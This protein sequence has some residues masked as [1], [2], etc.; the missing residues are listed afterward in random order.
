MPQTFSIKTDAFSAADLLLESFSCTE[1]LS[2][3]TE[4]TASLLSPRSDLDADLILGKPVTFTVEQR[5]DGARHF[6]GIVSRFSAVGQTGRFHRYQAVVRPWLWFLTRTTDCRIFQHQTV[7]DIVKTVFADHRIAVHDFKLFREYREREYC[8]QYRE[9]DFNFVS[10]LL[11]HEGIY[12]RF[13][14]VDGKHTLLLLDSG[15]A[16]DPQPDGAAELPFLGGTGQEPPDLDFVGRWTMSRSVQPGKFAIDDYDFE[17]P[18]SKLLTSGEQ[19]REHDLGDAEIYDYPGLFTKPADGVQLI[20]TRRDEV[21]SCFEVFSGST[22]ALALRVGFTFKLQRHPRD[23]QN[24]EYLVT[25]VNLQA[26]N[27]SLDAGLGAGAGFHCE[28]T[29]I[30]ASQQ[31]RPPRHSRRPYVQGAQTAVVVGAAGE[32]IHTDR[33]GRVR[34]QFRWDRLGKKDENSSCMVRVAQAWA[35]KNFGAIFIP[36]VGQEVIVDFLEGDPD[37]PI[38]VGSVHNAE[39]MPPWK[40]PDN[41]TQSGVLTRSSKGG[42]Y[43]NANEIRF[44]DKQGSELLSLHAERNMSTSV[45]VDDSTSVG[46]DQSIGI[47]RDQSLSVT[48]NRNVY[49]K[50]NESHIVD[51]A[52]KLKVGTNQ[53]NHVV[54]NQSTQVDGVH[55][56][57]VKGNLQT[58]TQANRVENTKGNESRTIKGS[59]SHFVTGNQIFDI[60]GNLSY[61][62]A[63]MVFE[64]G[65]IEHK[66]TGAN[67]VVH[68]SPNGPYSIM[69]NKIT[70]LSNTDVS[71]LAAGK[72]NQTSMENNVT[73]MGSNNSGYIGTASEVNMGLSR[74][75]FLGLAMDTFIGA[76]ISNTMALQFEAVLA[77]KMS[78]AVGPHLEMNTM[79][80]YCPGGG[81]GAG[82]ATALGEGASLLAGLGALEGIMV[83]FYSTV[84]GLD[85]ISN[86]YKDAKAELNEQAAAAEEAGHPG[87]ATR[88]RRLASGGD[89]GGAA[90]TSTLDAGGGPTAVSGGGGAFDGG[91]AQGNTGAPAGAIQ[92]GGDQGGSSSGGQ[93]GGTP[94]GG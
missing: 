53:D 33:F 68:T 19:R 88:L 26:K 47:N 80:M 23:D 50:E 9:S 7:P 89:L 85:E 66:V 59:E 34:V 44:E 18:S 3:L 90:P 17:K 61:K 1:G 5:N 27:G 11:E 82:G 30:A 60:T 92:S 79:K 76:S 16:H 65:H 8:V 52:Q 71:I 29:A 58:D 57:S 78:I 63:R 2:Q 38:I 70:L 67:S 91:G 20:E 93:G 21:E 37:Q 25:S 87:L 72:I 69:A 48:R 46:R 35:G 39:Q 43:A 83:G 14:H 42:A 86:Q 15:S 45:E 84:M 74:S 31:Y 40:L 32:E 22:N 51:L 73:V 55:T 10:R 94:G 54:G 49:V 41:A 36:R 81:G 6:H 24:A 28:F 62:A 12:Y 56:L 13:E 64:A 4:I 77:A 75:T